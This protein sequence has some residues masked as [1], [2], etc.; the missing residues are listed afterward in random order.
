[1]RFDKRW[2]L[3]GRGMRV[4]PG[5][6]DGLTLAG[7][8]QM[9]QA[10]VDAHGLVAGRQGLRGLIHQDCDMV[11]PRGVA[12]DGYAHGSD[13]FGQQAAPAHI[14]RRVMLGPGSACHRAA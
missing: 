3:C 14:E 7:H 4:E 5:V 9:G 11:A 2:A 13:P 1:M 6:F 12:G 8:R 10:H